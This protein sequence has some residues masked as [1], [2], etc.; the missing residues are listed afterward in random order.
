MAGFSLGGNQS[1]VI[2]R[3]LTASDQWLP[4]STAAQYKDFAGN[5]PKDSFGNTSAA[6][7]AEIAA[8]AATD[9]FI[10]QENV[11]VSVF[12][13]G[14]SASTVALQVYVPSWTGGA[15]WKTII[16]AS[17][18]ADGKMLTFMAP[19]LPWRV[20]VVT[21]SVDTLFVTV[22]YERAAYGRH[23]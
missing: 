18:W 14:L 23:A 7:A 6:I 22:I 10:N 11:P 2:H 20:G 5:T 17:E 3:Q 15:A 13:T 8:V 16:P 21:Y 1:L 12:F 19:T 9:G 4:T